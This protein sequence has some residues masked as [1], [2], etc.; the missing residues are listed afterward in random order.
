MSTVHRKIFL[1]L[2]KKLTYDDINNI[3]LYL[4]L[5]ILF[6]WSLSK[7][8]LPFNQ[9][10]ATLIILKLC[11]GQQFDG[12]LK[13]Y[14]FIFHAIEQQIFFIYKEHKQ[15]GYFWTQYIFTWCYGQKIRWKLHSFLHHETEYL[16][17][18]LALRRNLY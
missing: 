8:D 4:R 12:H 10:K 14:Y 2:N 18:A 17:M 15:L 1:V 11:K 9:S 16:P 5:L 7:A 3:V 13:D 6:I